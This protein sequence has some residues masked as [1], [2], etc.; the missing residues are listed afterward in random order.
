M[1][2]LVGRAY[3][4][5]GRLIRSAKVADENHVL[6]ILPIIVDR[7]GVPIIGLPKLSALVFP[8]FQSFAFT[9]QLMGV[10]SSYHSFSTLPF[11]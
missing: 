2:R 7:R 9:C 3:P 10:V 6:I 8:S 4:G 11:L 5:V 1:F